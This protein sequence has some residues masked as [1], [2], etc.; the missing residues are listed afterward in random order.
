MAAGRGAAGHGALLDAVRGL[1]WPARRPVDAGPAG[2]HHSR[3][4]G[5]SSELA[6]YRAYRQ[7]DDPRR[8]DWRLLARADRAYVRLSNDRA[9][10]PTLL[11]VDASA[12]MAFPPPAHDKWRLAR[13]VAI[14][15]AAV[16]HGQGDPVGLACA[17]HALPPRTRRGVVGEIAQ[18]LAATEPA[19]SPPLAPAIAGTAAR[20]IVVVSDLLEAG[21]ALLDAARAIGA[22]GGEA[23]VVHVVATEELH[24]PT[25]TVLAVDPED[26]TVRRP[27]TRDAIDA[28]ARDFAEWR[29][30]TAHAWR[31]AGATYVLA[32]T[33]EEPTRVVRRVLDPRAV[34]A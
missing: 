11:V 28:Y 23:H 17:A 6:E 18:L 22:R 24:P 7:G 13:D 29:A 12:S 19:G 16:A 15:L 31:A 8:I 34:P 33:D 32:T 14:A 5:P 1:R 21:D 2:V 10:L 25:R 20:R 27:L 4:R 3:Q 9:V 26:A 30:A